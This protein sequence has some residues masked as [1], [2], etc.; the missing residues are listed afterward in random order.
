MDSFNAQDVQR[1]LA[2]LTDDFGYRLPRFAR[3]GLG[4]ADHRETLEGFIAAVPDRT[5]AVLRT[6]V[7]G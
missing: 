4:L 7:A 1:H 2:L 6:I 5:I 3:T